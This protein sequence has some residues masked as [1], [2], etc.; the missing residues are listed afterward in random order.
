MGVVYSAEDTK[1]GRLAA[2]KL[3]ADVVR[4]AACPA[5]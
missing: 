3:Q 2:V 4:Q 1:L 5:R